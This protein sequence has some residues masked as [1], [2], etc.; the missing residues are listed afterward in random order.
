MAGNILIADSDQTFQ[1]DLQSVFNPSSFR[2]DGVDSARGALLK[3]NNKKFDVAIV[4]LELPDMDGIELFKTITQVSPKTSVIIITGCATLKSSIEA[5]RLGA[6]DYMLKPLNFEEIALKVRRLMEQKDFLEKAQFIH[7]ELN[8]KYNFNNIVACSKSMRNV[9]DLIRRVSNTGSNVLILGNSGTGKELVARA[10]H[11][12]SPRKQH[13][14]V[15]INCSA[16]IESLFES[17]LF[18]HKRGAFTNAVK[19]KDGLLKVA[20]KGTLFLDEIAGMSVHVQAKLLRA[21]ECKQ[22]TPIGGTEPIPIDIR[23][24]ASTN[25][26]PV[27]EIESGMFR[28]DL[29]YRL[30]VVEIRLPSLTERQEDIPLLAQHFVRKYSKELSKPVEGIAPNAMKK[31]MQFKWKGEV[32]ELENIIERAMIFCEGNMISAGDLPNNINN[33]SR[34]NFVIDYNKSLKEALKDFERHYILTKLKLKQGHRLKTFKELKLSESSFYRKIEELGM[35]A[36]ISD[37]FGSKVR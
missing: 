27:E 20:S 35:K 2:C 9:F 25:R 24:I 29:Y 10:I 18:G 37:W 13:Q 32:R 4:S 16:V 19:D 17:E 14:F 5:L 33:R 30:N 22:I 34:D 6:F 12:N 7:N 15:T 28:E 3:L 8:R 21:I 26:E 31:L 11:F 1:N 36:E 23:I